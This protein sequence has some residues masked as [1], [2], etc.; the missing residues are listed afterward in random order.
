MDGRMDN[1]SVIVA[2]ERRNYSKAPQEHV[3]EF[4]DSF[5]TKK[6]GKVT[7]IFPRSLYR[8][9]LPLE[10]LSL[11]TS[12]QNAADSYEAAARECR[13]RV[14]RIV[15]EAHRTNEKFTDPDFD[16]ATDYCRNT[17]DGLRSKS[18]FNTGSVHRV[19]WIFENPQ[20]TI[21]GCEASDI[22]QGAIGD[23]WW[24]AGT[25]TIAHRKDLMERVCVARDEEVGVYGFVFYRDGEWEPV[26][27][28]DSLYLSA[29]DFREDHDPTGKKAREWRRNHQT[30]SN[31][32]FFSKCQDPN[33]TWLP[34]MEKAYAKIHG[35]YHAIESGWAGQ[36]VEDMTGGVTA[37]LATNCVLN[38][39]KLWR[40]LS[41]QN[42]DFVFALASRPDDSDGLFGSHA[43]SILRATEVSGEDGQK[44]RL[45]QVRNPWG[46]GEWNGP[47]SDG[48]KEWTPYWLTKLG[49]TFGDDGVFWISYHDMLE[50]F[51]DI[52]RTRLFD[53]SWSVVQ[54]WATMNISWVTGYSQCKFSLEIKQG[55][56]VVITLAQ[57]DDR[58][59]R[60]LEGQYDFSLHF[61][62]QEQGAKSGDHICRVRAGIYNGNRSVSC[63]VE[64]EAGCY[65]VIP[66][67]TAT[68]DTSK[69]MV[70][71]IVKQRAQSN[72]QKLRQIGMQYD[73]AHAKA[74]ITDEDLVLHTKA[75]KKKLEEKRNAK[76]KEAKEKRRQ[77]R[78]SLKQ[79][80]PETKQTEQQTEAALGADHVEEDQKQANAKDI[81]E[82]HNKDPKA[83]EGKTDNKEN[84]KEEED[85][86]KK[87]EMNTVPVKTEP[88][89]EKAQGESELVKCKVCEEREKKEEEKD[90]KDDSEA[91]GSDEDDNDDSS[92]E[93]SDDFHEH[94]GPWNAVCV[95]GLRVYSQCEN[96]SVRLVEPKDPEE[97]ALLSVDSAPAGATIPERARNE[98]PPMETAKGKDVSPSDDAAKPDAEVRHP[99]K[100]SRS[101][102]TEEQGKAPKKRRKV[103][104]VSVGIVPFDVADNPMALLEE[105]YL[106]P[107]CPLRQAGDVGEQNGLILVVIFYYQHMTCDLERPCTRCIKRNIGHLC[108]DEPREHESKKAKSAL[109]TAADDSEHQTD[110][111]Q[112]SRD[113]QAATNT[114]TTY[115]G[116]MDAVGSGLDNGAAAA[117]L[118]RGNPL[119]V[120]QSPLTG[121]RPNAM[122]SEN[123]NS[124]PGFSDG[125]INQSHFHDMHGYHPSFNLITPEVTNEFNLLSDFLNGSLLEDGSLL[126]DEQSQNLPGTAQADTIVS[127]FLNSTGENSE[128]LNGTGNSM[129]PP[130]AI[131]HQKE[132]LSTSQGEL[133]KS[134]VRPSSTVAIDKARE[135]YLQAADPSGNDTAEER[136]QRLLKAKYDAG[137]LKPFNYIKGYSRLSNYLDSHIAATSKQ[138]ILRQ[139][140]RFRPKF[141]EKIHALTDIE[142]VYVEMWFEKTLM[143]YDR[144]FASMAIP[145]CCWRRTGEIF[146]GNKEMAELINVPVDDLRDCWRE[147]QYDVAEHMYTKM[148]ALL[149]SLTH[150]SVENLVEAIFEIGCHLMAKKDFVMAVKWLGR[151]NDIITNQS[152]D[153]LTE[154]GIKLRFAVSQAHIAA[155]MGV[156]TAEGFEKARGLVSY[157]ETEIGS[158]PFVLILKL[159]LLNKSPAETFDCEAYCGILREMIR[160]FNYAESTFRALRK[161]L[162]KLR[163]KSPSLG[164]KLLDEF[165]T[166]LHDAGFDKSESV[167]WYEKLVVLRVKMT[168]QCHESSEHLNTAKILFARCEHPLGTRGAVASQTLLWKM[169]DTK[170]SM[171]QFD[172]AQE[173]GHIALLPVFKE[174]GPNNRA[175]IER[176]L[177]LCNVSL[178]EPE[179]AMSIY[180]SMSEQ[181]QKDKKTSYVMFKVAIRNSDLELAVQCLETMSSASDS[182]DLIY[183]CVLDAQKSGDKA[184]V[185]E[186]LRKLVQVRKIRPNGPVHL[187]ALLRCSIRFL[188]KLMDDNGSSVDVDGAAVVHVVTMFEEAAKAIERKETGA[189]GTKLF[190]LQELEWFCQNAYNISVKYAQAWDPRCLVRT[191]DVCVRVMGHFPED[192]VSPVVD[193]LPLRRLFCHFINAS[194]LTALAR[195][196]KDVERQLLDYQAVRKNVAGFEEALEACRGRLRLPEAQYKQLLKKLQIIIVFDF[197][198]ALYLRQTS[199]L[200]EIIRRASICRNAESFKAM[201]DSLLRLHTVSKIAPRDFYSALNLLVDELAAL[202]DCDN[203]KLAR[204]SRWVFQVLMGI[205][206]KLALEELRSTCEM[207]KRALET[208]GS[209]WPREELEWIAIM[210]FNHGIEASGLNDEDDAQPWVEIAMSL[211]HYNSDG[212]ALE[213]SMYESFTSFRLNRQHGNG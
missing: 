33:E 177:L 78:S 212:G 17:L 59:F 7:S 67:I 100:A 41:S 146:R 76:E 185:V 87:T 192:A 35:D 22:V 12:T 211:A 61:V 196:Q 77:H 180:H 72:P 122:G 144:V 183:A 188:Q 133:G 104:L 63:E 85:G 128:T 81:R 205:D 90:E 189:D 49:H 164:M 93:S 86:E 166:F 145:A 62:L 201:A 99:L 151:S 5:F 178:N 38:K 102:G 138:K 150:R 114:M 109:G 52:S 207:A 174:A 11:S 156:E 46:D 143:D 194:A 6:P 79:Q 162:A 186:A 187:P 148:E 176:K 82:E 131:P 101:G 117:V 140:D 95:V 73:L 97:G 108:H 175:K 83:D 43:Y 126:Q 47:W 159:E 111:T 28:D 137:L 74:G 121:V 169:L 84:I 118:G 10:K 24:L 113:G 15:R 69:D 163:D 34:L 42:G 29:P 40:E 203:V 14:K 9:L 19:D 32:L 152:I 172:V 25:A 136:M 92:S 68:R 134:I 20:F 193:D 51:E 58:Y 213:T 107:P 200:G 27:V 70:E 160:S 142:L 60:G 105:S 96:V 65:E 195:T 147:E 39:D 115:D 50:K 66:K 168:T 103:L 135:Y 106:A 157:I 202:P 13:E 8:S 123:L 36:A 127:S 179:A 31:A 116:R 91:Y 75:E 182:E 18:S 1:Q 209:H 154:D 37:N 206:T 158:Q 181:S 208:T 210:A 199:E 89:A 112:T 153:Q 124:F 132:A 129:L 88:N 26:L 155:L 191:L 141:R 3:S 21:N 57:L 171:K 98:W 167:E 173:W 120:P 30:G 53:K 165:V 161:H 80:G 190:S 44:V 170:F 64:L 110:M 94:P 55:G 45:V 125:W 23:C 54:Q 204:Y 71:D 198:S 56:L 48:S 149:P 130:S 16:L 197:E 2:P 119:L 139:L 4:W 184:Y